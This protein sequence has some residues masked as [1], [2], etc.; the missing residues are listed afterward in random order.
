MLLRGWNLQNRAF[1][2]R[3]AGSSNADLR[4]PLLEAGLAMADEAAAR[5]PKLAGI[6]ELRGTLLHQLALQ[7]GTPVDSV[8]GGLAI[9]EAELRRA[10]ELD[11]QS[12]SAWRRLADVLLH[13]TERYGEAKQAAER[14]YRLDPYAA[15]ANALIYLLFTASLEIGQDDQAEGWCLEGRRRFPSEP[16]FLYC[17]MAL[18][19]W[20]DAIQPDPPLLQRAMRS[21]Q[22]VQEQIQPQMIARFEAMLAA[23]Y[24]RAGQ[25]DSARAVLRRLEDVAG[26]PGLLWLRAAGYAALHEDS[27]ATDLLEQYIA[28]GGWGGQ[29]VAKT[30]P[31]RHLRERA[32][33]RR[34]V[35]GESGR[36]PR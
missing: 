25:P 31:F 5:D 16:P 27:I 23:A 4:Q 8:R 12:Q 11:P 2:T 32:A 35:T 26:D 20:A 7:P 1:I 28:R 33:T 34:V 19:A 24:A 13:G 21:F 17:L 30:R 22:V 3:A 15:E 14:A 36:T 9:A 29:R 18:H 10:V 6:Y